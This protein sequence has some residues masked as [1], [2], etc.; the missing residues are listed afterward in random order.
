VPDDK[1]MIGKIGLDPLTN[2]PEPA[3]ELHAR[4]G[5]IADGFQADDVINAAL[6]IMINTLR[7]RYPKKKDAD[8]AVDRL[9]A[10]TRQALADHYFANGSRRS[11][12]PFHQVIEVPFLDFKKFPQG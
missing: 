2:A 12:F 3:R 9:L 4:F 8:E 7:Q 5:R 10:K 6:N 1:L 11:I